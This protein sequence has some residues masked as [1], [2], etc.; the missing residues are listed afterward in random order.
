[1]NPPILSGVIL[2]RSAIGVT[3]KVVSASARSPN[4][5]KVVVLSARSLMALTVTVKVAVSSA[6][7]ANDGGGGT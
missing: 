6:R 3:I 1:M 5:P 4:T 7:N 2:R